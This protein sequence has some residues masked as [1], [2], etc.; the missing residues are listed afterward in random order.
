MTIKDMYSDLKLYLA[1]HALE[2]A[3]ILL[4]LLILASIQFKHLPC[5]SYD[6]LYYHCNMWG[7]Q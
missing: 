5:P 7:G 2:V 3:V 4:A 1:M 6:S